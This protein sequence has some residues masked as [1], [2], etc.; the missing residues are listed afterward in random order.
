MLDAAAAWQGLAKELASAADSFG[1]VTSALVDGSWQGASAAAMT[2]VAAP[3]AG[4]LG[5]VAA[6]AQQAAAQAGAFVS[7]FEAVQSAMVRPALVAANR[8][9]LVSLALS[10]LFGQNAPAIA[11]TESAYEE[12]WALDVAVMAAY[13]SGASTVVSALTPFTAPLANVAG[14]PAQAAAAL[15]NS[16]APMAAAPA[17]TAQLIGSTWDWP[18]LAVEMLVMPTTGW[19][20]SVAET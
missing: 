8:S 3:Y 10:N 1:S 9:D 20:I 18:T 12:M 7:E 13:H 4:W 16:A 19:A 17:A 5:A 15:M 2:A 11:A 14:V 6:Q